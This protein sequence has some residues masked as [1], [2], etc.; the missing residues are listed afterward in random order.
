[1]RRLPWITRLIKF[2][3]WT[4]ARVTFSK[5][6]AIREIN[7]ASVGRISFEWNTF[8]R[9]QKRWNGAVF[10]K[11]LTFHDIFNFANFF[12]IFVIY[13]KD[14][15][16]C[17]PFPPIKLD[18]WFS[19]LL[20]RVTWERLVRAKTVLMNHESQIMFMFIRNLCMV[21]GMPRVRDVKSRV[22]R[23]H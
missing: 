18:L 11:L 4:R 19:R 7:F 2:L 1:M 21:L 10:H 22:N 8:G 16:D 12:N 17:G 3:M 15:K 20:P 13:F 14:K 23:P 5:P 6:D 9:L